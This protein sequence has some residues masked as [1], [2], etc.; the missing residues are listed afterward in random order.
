MVYKAT[1][2]TAG[3]HPVVSQQGWNIN[4]FT[5]QFTTTNL[6]THSHWQPQSAYLWSSMNLFMGFHGSFGSSLP[7]G[8]CK[9]RPSSLAEVCFVLFWQI[10]WN[11]WD[12]VLTHSHVSGD[13]GPCWWVILGSRL[14]ILWYLYCCIVVAQRGTLCNQP[15]RSHDRGFWKCEC[16]QLHEYEMLPV[17]DP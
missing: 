9:H 11:H 1:N 13:R 4:Q 10:S 17:P 8:A 7:T 6:W 15:V 16:A 12:W 3:H 14:W 2:I 5:N